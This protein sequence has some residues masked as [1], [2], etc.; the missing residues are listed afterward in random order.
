MA[1]TP[2]IIKANDQLSSLSDE[3]LAAIATLSANDETTVINTK[4]GEIHGQYEADIKNIAGVDKNDGEK[5]YDYMKRI[6][7]DYK[8]KASGSAEYETKLNAAKTKITNLEKMIQ[9]GKGNEAMTQ[10]LRDAEDQFNQLKTLYEGDKS[11]WEESKKGFESKITKI[12]VD[13]QFSDATRGLKFKSGYP[14][15]VQKTLLKSAKAAILGTYTPDWIEDGAGN[16]KMV[17]R[18]GKG[19][20]AR[21]KANALNPYTATELIHEQLREVI[22]TGRQ[23]KGSGSKDPGKGDQDLIDLVDIAGAK[24]QVEADEII[25]KYLLQTGETRGSQS[26]ADKQKQ[27]RDKNNVS[28]LPIR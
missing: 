19:E 22:D 2:D 26:F 28:K 4:I 1:L 16:T 18:D 14:E 7:G 3:Q 10:K 25:S 24:S 9:E 27:L 8:T 5:A 21:N 20:I 13:N 6:L 12:Q 11:K 17:F 15:G 23:Q